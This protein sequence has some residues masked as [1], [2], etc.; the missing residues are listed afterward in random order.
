MNKRTKA[1]RS[2][3]NRTKIQS[4]PTA[5][6]DAT[7]S[8]RL[9]QN[10]R[11]KLRPNVGLILFV[12][13]ACLVCL[14]YTLVTNQIWEDSLITLRHSENLLKGEGLTYNAGEK[15]HGFTSPINVLLLVVC[16]WLTGKSSYV[17]TFWLYR[18]FTIPAFAV[19]G[20]LLLKA[21]DRTPPRWT[22]ATWFLGVVYLFDVKSLA[23][24]TNGMEAAFMLLF[25]AWAV[26]LMSRS[27]TDRW[28]LRGLCWG[29]MMWTRPD[30]C[31][32]IVVFSIAELIFLST[33]RR[34]TFVALA[35]AAAVCA[36]VYAPWFVWAW[37]YYGSPIPHTITAKTSV[38]QGPLGQLWA[39]FDN[40]LSILIFQSGQA[41]RPI[42]YPAF[43]T[44]WFRPAILG[45]VFNGL[46]R[47]IGV[48][49]LLY[50]TYPVQDRF[51]RAMSL[52]F[53]ILCSYFA[54]MSRVY[55]WYFPPVTMLGA[56]AFTRAATSFAFAAR[57][58]TVRDV[59]LGMRNAFVATTFFVLAVCNIL[60]IW[61]MLQIQRVSQAE[62]EEG[63]A[64]IGKWLKENALATDSVYLEP[65]GYIGYFS[66]LHMDDFPGL[67]SP[68]V[69]RIRRQL[70]PDAEPAG[71]YMLLVIP[72]LKP[73]WVVLRRSE[74]ELLQ[75]SPPF[76]QQFLKDYVLRR[77]F[78]ITDKLNE[79]P[80][81]PAKRYHLFDAYFAVFHRKTPSP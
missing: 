17:A 43:P 1:Q 67:V 77:E 61:P 51:G 26:Y 48:V 35:K 13:A 80:S 24:S 62:V 50:F 29:G 60:L 71:A 64:A 33:S 41:F 78:D 55:P 52:C 59:R 10:W 37:A 21:I 40:Y 54:C 25:M 34:A 44:D 2:L 49:A 36:V 45:Q 3:A 70:P 4:A 46:T 16:S 57:D 38:E 5:L 81:L 58:G 53:A 68:K 18:A 15:V 7:S 39:T 32:Y 75:N 19:S 66:G 79:Y 72:E 69:V 11:Q 8:A 22:A 12:A 76:A 65:L 28:L 31:V 73:D 27:E 63:R 14:I 42:Y 47:I 74:Y 9:S 20:V 6:D 56:V 30:G 23:Y